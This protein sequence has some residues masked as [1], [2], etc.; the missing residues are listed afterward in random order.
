MRLVIWDAIAPFMTS[1]YWKYSYSI[2]YW[3]RFNVSFSLTHPQQA[4]FYSLP[5]SKIRFIVTFSFS[6]FEIHLMWL[7]NNHHFVSTSAWVSH[8]Q[9]WHKTQPHQFHGCHQYSHMQFSN[10]C[11]LPRTRHA[12]FNTVIA[13]IGYGLGNINCFHEINCQTKTLTDLIIKRS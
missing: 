1:S 9:S 7:S 3:K 4:P 2:I 5:S 8:N 10:W 6:F 12:V 11:V 13:G